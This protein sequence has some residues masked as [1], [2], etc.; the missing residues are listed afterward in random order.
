M[1]KI[2]NNIIIGFFIVFSINSNFGVFLALP[3]LLILSINKSKDLIILLPLSLI[4]GYIFN[5]EYILIILLLYLY[6]ILYLLIINKKKKLLID[7]ILNIIINFITLLYLNNNI[8]LTNL[9]WMLLL[10]VS[11]V[12]IY[13][14][15][16]LILILKKSDYVYFELIT[17]LIVILSSSLIDIDFNISFILAVLYIMY[18]S[19]IANVICS[20]V[21][22]FILTIY[23]YLLYREDI[24][25][26]LP[27][28]NAIYL[29]KN[30]I[31]S[32]ILVVLLFIISLFFKES[33]EYC[34]CI[35]I[36]CIIYELTRRTNRT[37]RIDSCENIKIEISKK[38]NDDILIFCN[39]LDD[40]V[41]DIEY[42]NG[43]EN[44][45]LNSINNIKDNYCKRCHVKNKCFNEN[46]NHD[47][48][49]R[50][51]I[52]NCNNTNY[53]MYNNELMSKCPYNIEIRKSALIASK[54]IDFQNIEIKNKIIKKTFW[55]ITN[56]LR[57]YVYDNNLKKEIDY[58]EI[59]KLKKGLVN[60][61]YD[62]FLFN[63]KNIYENN[64]I[65]EIGINDIINKD[66]E[67]ILKETVTKNFKYPF[68][69][70][71]NHYENDNSYISI[72]N[73]KKVKVEYS[74]SNIAKGCV[75]GDNVYVKEKEGLFVAGICDGMGKG[76][77]ANK[78]SNQ[79]IGMLD[80]LIKANVS[81]ATT[82]E[83]I[84]LY[85]NL[86]EEYDTFSTVDLIEINTINKKSFIYKMAAATSYIFHDNKEIEKIENKLLPIGN[87]EKTQPLEI[88]IKANDVIIMSSDGLFDN[89][90]NENDL[91]SY[92]SNVIHLPVE[93][94][95]TQIINYCNKNICYNEDDVS[96]VVIKI[97]DC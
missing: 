29:L 13:F 46:I 12:L 89:S 81:V 88:D 85:C 97:L 92:I 93:K 9:L 14:C 91:L 5:R 78:I 15:L 61:G 22:S 44:K 27:V 38:I 2:I 1:R 55:S 23:F 10:T 86:K 56:L 67:K 65:L 69:L 28:I 74:Y 66:K 77:N 20:Y 34:L 24:Y 18:F 33:I 48:Q 59:N 37:I 96:I 76:N 54:S 49:L 72:Y 6:I 87:E 41:N 40:C 47:K 95:L 90:K 68:E 58:L 79:M 21:F 71:I 25:F 4:S 82:L 30:I 32:Y 19:N 83:I 35:S 64:F 16:Y 39:F 43:K 75:S 62:I 36:I 94:I 80:S 63:I 60:I 45:I 51:L 31:S 73:K 53:S 26:I 50:S 52:L 70:E 11:S 84:N 8:V 3:I 17:M 57:E 7:I 42:L